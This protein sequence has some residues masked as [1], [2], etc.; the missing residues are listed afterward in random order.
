M[1]MNKEGKI[2]ILIVEDDPIIAEDLAQNMNDFGYEAL[3]PVDNAEEAMGV[4]RREQ[5]DLILF[6]VHLGGEI[7]GIELATMVKAKFDIPFIYLTAFNDGETFERIK[8]TGP[9]AYLI[10][11]VDDNNLETSI[12]VALYNHANK[13]S[14]F[15]GEKETSEKM[16][17]FVADEYIF[18]K[19]KHE[20]R[21]IRLQDILFAEA[22]DNYAFIYT[23]K[24]KHIVSSS[25]KVVESRLPSDQFIRTHRSYVINL[26]K[27]DRIEE[28]TLHIGKHPIPIGKTYREQLMSRIQQL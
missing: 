20:L 2:R 28:N 16:N 7:D 17:E 10:K 8:A 27:I 24:G 14:A 13:K 6:D 26:S 25:L 18:I 4:I 5:P 22:Y 1:T 3:K 11:P 23:D 19:V 9:S 15:E 21:K 12:A